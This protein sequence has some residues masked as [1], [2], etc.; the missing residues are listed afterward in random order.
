MQDI[1]TVKATIVISLFKLQKQKYLF[2]HGTNHAAIEEHH[3]THYTNFKL[4]K[5]HIQHAMCEFSQFRLNLFLPWQDIY[6]KKRIFHYIFV[7]FS[8]CS[9]A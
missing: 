4:L 6:V 2:V 3:V 7:Y 5:Y 1:Y 8:F 9:K